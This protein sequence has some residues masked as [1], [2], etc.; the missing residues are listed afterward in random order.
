MNNPDIKTDGSINTSRLV[1]MFEKLQENEQLALLR[2]LEGRLSKGKRAHARKSFFMVVDYATEDG[3]YK[4]FIQDISMGGLFIETSIPFLLGKE[5]SLTFPLPSISKHI[6][7]GGEI[8]RVSDRGI[9]IKFMVGDQ[10]QIDMIK[11]LLEHI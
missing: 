7:I 4:D 11:T 3:N 10:E 6:K 5:I 9:G 1:E 2:E 8:V